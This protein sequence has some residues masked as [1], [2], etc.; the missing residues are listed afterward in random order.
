M[1]NSTQLKQP[2]KEEIQ[3]HSPDNVSGTSTIGDCNNRHES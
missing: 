1:L 3:Q 2:L